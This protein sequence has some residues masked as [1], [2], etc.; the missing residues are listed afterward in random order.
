MKYT[1]SLLAALTAAFLSVLPAAHADK[2]EQWIKLAPKDTFFTLAM[3]DTQEVLADWDK[4]SFA[5][6]MQDEEA[7]RW[8]EPTKEDGE[9]PWDKHFKEIYG[10]GLYDTLKEARG[11]TVVFLGSKGVAFE[12]KENMFFVALSEAGDNEARLTEQ[13]KQEIENK[14]KKH[15]NLKELTE[16]IHG[17]TVHIRAESDAADAKWLDA[18]A[19]I[20]GVFVEGNNREGLSSM[21]AALKSG[22]GEGGAELMAQAARVSQLREGT[23]DIFVHLNLK[24]LLVI[25]K[26]AAVEGMKKSKSPVPVT[27]EQIFAALGLDAFESLAFTV[28]MQDDR[29]TTDF[30]IMHK[31]KPEGILSWMRH[32]ATEVTLPAFMPADVAAASVGRFDWVNFYDGLMG[33]VMKL[34]PQMGMMAAMG[35]GSME[36]QAGFKLRDDFFASLGDEMYQAQDGVD[37]LKQSQVIGFTVKNSEKLGSALKGLGNMLST[38]GFGAFEESDYL[39]YT[40]NSLKAAKSNSGGQEIAYCNTGKQLFIGIGQLDVMKKVLGRLKD[41]AGPSLWDSPR[42]QAQLAMLPKGNNGVGVTDFSR[43]ISTFFTAMETISKQQAGMKKAGAAKKKGPG[44]GPAKSG[45]ATGAEKNSDETLAKLLDAKNRPS[46]ATFRKYFGTML[47]SSYT[48]A[49]CIHGRSL[50][51]PVEAK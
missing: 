32:P 8:L 46:D 39:G 6:F 12:K 25:A 36:Q 15:A 43:L 20:D 4:S 13:K 28:D 44:K 51:T 1:R 18:H 26:K 29:S 49:D 11:S 48:H 2:V 47:S 10:T 21:I 3:K 14:K 30:F 35:L 40:L 24:P 19:I 42:T 17:V 33:A 7:V 16:E 31:E 27:A 22:S 45:D 50:T 37:A 23:A 38:S 41:P 9:F 5:K 34:S